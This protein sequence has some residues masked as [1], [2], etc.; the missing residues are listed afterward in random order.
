MLVTFKTEAYES[1]TFFGHIAQCLLSMMGQ[2]GRI[3]GAILAK[4]VAQALA[5]LSKALESQQKQP[6]PSAEQDI[7]SDISLSHR[8]LPLLGLLQAAADK[9]CDVLWE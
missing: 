9:H 7:E 8:A 5:L 3:P 6:K 1:L 4:D 2:S